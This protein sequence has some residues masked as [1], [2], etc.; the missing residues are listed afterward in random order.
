MSLILHAISILFFLGGKVLSA[1]CSY[2][3]SFR[4]V[5]GIFLKLGHEYRIPLRVH[6][7]RLV[8]SVF[9]K[10]VES[11]EYFRRCDG[12]FMNASPS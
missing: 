1:R 9:S 8:H 5:F 7:L 2:L 11:R 10:S 4:F 12:T 6:L 3:E